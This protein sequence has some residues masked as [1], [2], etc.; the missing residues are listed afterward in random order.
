LPRAPFYI[1][2][3]L[4]AVQEW[5]DAYLFWFQFLPMKTILNM[6]GQN[7]IHSDEIK[8]D[9]DIFAISFPSIR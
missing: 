6:A 9:P 5:L 2:T 3:P 4:E 7:L 1:D 8:A